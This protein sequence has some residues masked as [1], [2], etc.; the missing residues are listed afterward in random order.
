MNEE[1]LDK[2]K[3]KRLG[4]DAGDVY[5][6]RPGKGNFSI[7]RYPKLN[8]RSKCKLS[9]IWNMMGQCEGLQW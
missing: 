3:R 7:K 6:F 5:I 1:K 8:H 4:W 9:L 2:W